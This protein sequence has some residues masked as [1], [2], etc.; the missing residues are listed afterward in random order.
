MSDRKAPKPT[1]ASLTPARWFEQA[2]AAFR[3][4]DGDEPPPGTLV[5]SLWVHDG[6]GQPADRRPLCF[7]EAPAVSPSRW[8]ELSP[9]EEAVIAALGVGRMTG[10]EL[11]RAI[12]R[13]YRDPLKALLRNLCERDILEANSHG[14]RL[15]PR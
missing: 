9:V 10:P 15:R 13:P 2:R 6:N 8:R 14:Y 7:A 3:D 5:I 11:A 4:R 1:R 12:R